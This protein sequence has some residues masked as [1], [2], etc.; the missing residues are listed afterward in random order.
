MAAVVAAAAATPAKDRMITIGIISIQMIET[1][2][3]M[4]DNKDMAIHKIKIHNKGRLRLFDFM[5]VC[6]LVCLSRLI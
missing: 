5:Y 2:H 4:A 1:V 3:I 6:W